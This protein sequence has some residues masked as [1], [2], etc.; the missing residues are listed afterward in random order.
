[1]EG[2]FHYSD[3]KSLFSAQHWDHCVLVVF[4]LTATGAL[5]GQPN[6]EAN[7]RY[8]SHELALAVLQPNTF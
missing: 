2:I 4:P 5:L 8:G 1:M 3:E 7:E 6:D